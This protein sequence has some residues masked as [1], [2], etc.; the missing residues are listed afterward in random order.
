LKINKIT[1]DKC[2]L[3]GASVHALDNVMYFVLSFFFFLAQK[4]R[5]L[6]VSRFSTWFSFL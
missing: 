5:Y 3:I 6:Q 4:S 1:H 2:Y